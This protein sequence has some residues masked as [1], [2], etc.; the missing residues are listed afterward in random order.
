MSEYM[1]M[2]YL[3]ILIIKIVEVYKFF[4]STSWAMTIT[5]GVYPTLTPSLATISKLAQWL[6]LIP[7]MP[8]KVPE[9]TSK[10]EMFWILRQ[11]IR[12]QAH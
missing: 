5:D 6:N 4:M 9:V 12:T 11:L 2:L 8:A 3:F 10:S 1:K 7:I